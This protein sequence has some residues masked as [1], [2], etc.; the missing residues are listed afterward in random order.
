MIM[1]IFAN[2]K[3][4]VRLGNLTIYGQWAGILSGFSFGVMCAWSLKSYWFY[5]LR[6]WLYLNSFRK[7]YF[8]IGSLN[9]LLL[10]FGPL[11]L[12]IPH[13][14][15]RFSWMVPVTYALFCATSGVS[16]VKLM[17]YL[18]QQHPPMTSL[19]YWILLLILYSTFITISILLLGL[20]LHQ[21]KPV[22]VGFYSL[23]AFVAFQQLEPWTD[24]VY[25]DP[26]DRLHRLLTITSPMGIP[27]IL[28]I[29]ASTLYCAAGY[30]GHSYV[31]SRALGGSGV[32][33][34]DFTLTGLGPD[35]EA[36]DGGQEWGR[37]RL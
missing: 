18:L 3:K 17:R 22:R 36:M 35:L 32:E 29:G 10:P 15:I 14:R 5:T 2:I 27:A 8:I 37:I 34:I 24:L 9:R 25:R 12:E 23:F 16:F 6:H 30:M 7:A 26:L 21:G 28:A 33:P 4:D 19:P 11:F 20:S 1:Q 13:L 31:P